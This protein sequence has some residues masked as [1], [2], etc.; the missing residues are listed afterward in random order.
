MLRVGLTGGIACGKSAVVRELRAGGLATIDLDAVAHAVMAPGGPV[1]EKVVEAFGA[2]VVAADGSID[3]RA[4]GAIVFADG[5]A[6]ARLNG[7]VHPAVRAEEKARAA[8]IEGEGHAVVV[9]EAALLVEAGAHLRFDR[10]VVVHCPPDE[11]LRRLQGRDGISER[12]ARSRLEAQMPIGEKRRFA[13]LEVD[14]GGSLAET[15]GAARELAQALRRE[16]AAPRAR[17]QAVPARALGALV[18]GEGRGPRG[19]GPH[20]LLEQ[21][22]A[23]GGI[24]MGRLAGRLEPPWTGPWYRASRAGEREPWPEVLAGPLALWSLVRGADV[25]WMDAAAASL[26]RLTH[27]EPESVAGACLA[28]R[29]ARDVLAGGSV[30][31]LPRRLPEWETVARRWGGTAPPLRIGSAAKAAASHPADARAARSDAA[32]AA[33]EPLLSGFLAGAVSGAPGNAASRASASLVLRLGPGARR[34]G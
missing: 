6:R 10:L 7:L 25:E 9:S 12:E 8:R 15:A 13:H 29:A 33:A 28:A 2:R 30:E 14:T 17:D 18:H 22:M 19:L 32:A 5:D 21:A 26:A 1:Y 4:L 24:E 31:A 20:L 23:D 3:R 16:S 11:Q 27:D 34:G